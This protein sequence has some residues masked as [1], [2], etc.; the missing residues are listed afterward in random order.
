MGGTQWEEKEGTGLQL[1][2]TLTPLPTH[3]FHPGC[4]AWAPHPVRAQET[5]LSGFRA[6]SLFFG[7]KSKRDRQRR[8]GGRGSE[9]PSLLLFYPR[10]QAYPGRSP[11]NLVPTVEYHH[12]HHHTPPNP[13]N[14]GSELRRGA[15][16]APA[17]TLAVFFQGHLTQLTAR[18]T[19]HE[20]LCSRDGGEDRVRDNEKER[21]RQGK[22]L[23][24]G[25][26]RRAHPPA[27]VLAIAPPPTNLAPHHRHATTPST[28]LP[29]PAGHTTLAPAP[30]FGLGAAQWARTPGHRQGSSRRS[31][32]RSHSWAPV[33][34]PRCP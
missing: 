7:L 8:G 12:V 21:E 27:A 1:P 30:A 31:A 3:T 5:H 33:A 9:K 20:D 19:D 24:H 10:S 32:A 6:L 28:R 23:L 4:W 11:G 16:L 25:L 2:D 26:E 18:V 34:W 13:G 29:T 17:F 14:P 22:G 15:W